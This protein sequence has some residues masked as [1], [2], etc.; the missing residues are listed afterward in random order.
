V[1]LVHAVVGDVSNRVDDTFRP[2]LAGLDD[3]LERRVANHFSHLVVVDRIVVVV[4]ES[5]VTTFRE[6]RGVDTKVLG[7]SVTG[8]WKSKR[9]IVFLSNASYSGPPIPEKNHPPPK[10]RPPLQDENPN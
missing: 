1:G 3:A 10:K 2:A 4:H 9:Q 8:V 6:H 5:C 7:R